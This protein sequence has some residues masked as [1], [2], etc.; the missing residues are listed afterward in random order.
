MDGRAA[1]RRI[2]KLLSVRL[3]NPLMRR[4]L[5]AGLVP[6][7]WALLET[8]GRRS[9]L[10]RRVPVGD[11]L[12]DGRFWIVAEHGRHADYVRNIER[13]PRVRVKVRNRWHSGTARLLPDDDPRARLR[14]LHR[15]LNDT[16][17]RAMA[18]EPLVLRVDLDD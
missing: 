4:A 5:E 2:S 7:G 18:T 6:R 14:W 9:G 8:T 15:P 3:L 10:P 12:R 17:L 13:D 1:K 11:G 16:G